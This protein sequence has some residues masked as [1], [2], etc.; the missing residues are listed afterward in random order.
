MIGR[1]RFPVGRRGRDRG[2]STARIVLLTRAGCHLCADARVAIER[3][4]AEF[5]VS[6]EERDISNDAV[7][8]ARWGNWVPVTLLD[9][10]EY[11][12]FRVD[13]RRLRRVLE[14]RAGRRPPGPPPG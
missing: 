13:E 1:P 12:V 8:L 7:A 4:V 10:V 5:G 3:L 11:G 14:A 2:A 9:G 6:W